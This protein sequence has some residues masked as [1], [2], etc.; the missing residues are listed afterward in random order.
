MRHSGVVFALQRRRRTDQ[1]AQSGTSLPMLRLRGLGMGTV[2]MI[3]AR[4]DLRVDALL[5]L[6]PVIAAGA[7]ELGLDLGVEEPHRIRSLT[8]T[9]LPSSALSGCPSGSSKR[10]WI[11]RRRALSQVG[12]QR[13]TKVGSGPRA[14]LPVKMLTGPVW[15]KI[16]SKVS[17]RFADFN[18]CGR[19]WRVRM[20]RLPVSAVG[21][22]AK[23]DSFRDRPI[24][25]L[26]HSS[27]AL[28]P[29]PEP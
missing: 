26:S 25:P 22:R 23:P 8:S 10:S 21:R 13:Q 17:T 7:P 20:R 11:Q 12:S 18:R 6:E 5:R 14:R 19:A 28:L 4:T 3:T 24:R 29:F 9:P 2:G 27:S 1:G 16:L 15:S